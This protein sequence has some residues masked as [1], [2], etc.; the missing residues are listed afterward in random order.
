MDNITE[1]SESLAVNVNKIKKIFHYPQNSDLMIRELYLSSIKR[2]AVLFYMNGMVNEQFL[3]QYVIKP[4]VENT[5]EFSNSAVGI[6]FIKNSLQSSKIRKLSCYSDIVKDILDGRTILIIDGYAAALSSNTIKYEHRSVERSETENVVKG[7]HESFVESP[8]VNRSLIRK[9]LKSSNLVTEAINIYVDDKSEVYI[10]YNKAIAN[11]EL[12]NEVRQRINKIKQNNYTGMVTASIIQQYIEDSSL[13]LPTLLY[14]ELPDRAASFIKEGHVVVL[15]DSSP[16]SLIAPATFW[17]F[18]HTPEDMYFRLLAGNFIRIVRIIAVF[19]SLFTPAIY[20]AITNYHQEMIPTDLLLA[21]SA[22]RERVP[23]PIVFE[24]VGM[25]IAFEIIR[26]CSFRIPSNIGSTIGIVGTLVLGQAAV[27]ANIISPLLVIIIAITGLSGF[28]VS[29]IDLNMSLRVSRFF[30][31]FCAIMMGFLGLAIGITAFTAY[32][33]SV[34]SFG[35]PFFS[36]VTPYY[37]SSM[38]MLIRSKVRNQWLKA[39]FTNPKLRFK[40]TPSKEE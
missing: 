13:L 28:S 19:I 10:M 2:K 16:S 27:Q 18:F 37:E 17:S 8:L 30:F 5:S 11:P 31:T 23:F 32:V 1:L 29:N 34:K 35:V 15:A 7:P 39:L 26:E 22:T 6:E 33:V 25:E 36:P 3:N 9:H 38:D 24:V 21:I 20:I 4:L 14:T 12:V 40:K